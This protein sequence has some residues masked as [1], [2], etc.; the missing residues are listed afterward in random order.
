MSEDFED[1][2]IEGY[3]TWRNNINIGIPPLINFLIK[4]GVVVVYVILIGILLFSFAGLSGIT[5]KTPY[6]LSDL[7]LLLETMK[8]IVWVI[9]ISI[10]IIL[11][12][13]L[14]IDSFF[15]AGAIGMAKEATEKGVTKLDDM[16]SYGKRKF[17]S[18][19][20]VKIILFAIIYIIPLFL[21]I[22]LSGLFGLLN[23]INISLFFM[24]ILIGIFLLYISILNIILSP[25]QYALIVSDLGTIDGIREGYR[26][27]LKNKLSVVLII[28]S[29][30]AI[31]TI[32]NTIVGTIASFFNVIPY[33]G[34]FIRLAI[35]FLSLLISSFLIEGVSI[36]LWTRF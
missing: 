21:I 30:G 8:G 6:I 1:T 26:F 18:L 2:L 25:V 9:L 34:A 12:L 7:N 31:S 5:E 33:I 22:G 17:I 4:S 32:F 3:K 27:F 15:T 11:L 24:F 19:F 35:V 20:L 14:L 13:S 28:I 36:T 23:M 16:M 29:V 10:P